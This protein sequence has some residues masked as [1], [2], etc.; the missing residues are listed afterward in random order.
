MKDLF[1]QIQEE[2][3]NVRQQSVEGELSNLDALIK[4]RNA[5]TEAEKVLEIVKNFE[6]E[7]LNEISA[8]AESYNGKYCGFEIKAVNG[9]KTFSFK[10]IEEIENKEA[11]KK[12][13]CEKYQSA[14]DGFQKGTVQ[15]VEEE[16]VRYWID[17]NGELKKFPELSIGKSYLTVKLSK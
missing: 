5:K 14:F 2:L 17:E 1:M 9:R 16:G 10:G 8:E 12:Q 11:E 13:L 15:T 3:H 7:R 4:M 6:D